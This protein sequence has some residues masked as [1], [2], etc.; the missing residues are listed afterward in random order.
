[1]MMSHRFRKW[2]KSVLLIIPG[3]K[4]GWRVAHVWNLLQDVQEE[5]A[6]DGAQ[7]ESPREQTTFQMWRMWKGF[8]NKEQPDWTSGHAH[9]N[10]A[11]PGN[12]NLHRERERKIWNLSP[13][14]ELI[15]T[16][17]HFGNVFFFSV[18]S[19]HSA[20]AT[21]RIWTVTERVI[22]FQTARRKSSSVQSVTGSTPEGVRSRHTWS[23]LAA[24]EKLKSWQV[25]PPL[26]FICFLIPKIGLETGAFF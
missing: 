2:S 7:R 9:R 1:M 16:P 21:S 8:Q 24:R 3:L 25:W 23:T 22:T 14:F 19:A 6:S 5:E 11:L 10:K 20:L 26:S 17:F 18:T 13:Y 12:F 15:H 4:K